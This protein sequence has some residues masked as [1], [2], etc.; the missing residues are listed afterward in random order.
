MGHHIDDKENEVFIKAIRSLPLTNEEIAGRMRIDS[1]RISHY[2]NGTKWP[3]RNTL[4]LFHREFQQ[5]LHAIEEDQR[6]KATRASGTLKENLSRDQ[7][8]DPSVDAE[9]NPISVIMYHVAC[10]EKS[11]LAIKA[12]F[13]VLQA[14]PNGG[15]SIKKQA[16][17]SEQG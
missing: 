6:K 15:K 5:D 9:Q 1:T 11:L 12:A 2:R 13:A 10:I 16:S 8:A 14:G 17:D 3:S 7:S 4:N